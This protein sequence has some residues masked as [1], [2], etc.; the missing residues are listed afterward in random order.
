LAG[1]GIKTAK[2]F[3]AVTENAS[4]LAVDTHVHRVLN[5]IGIVHTK[6][7]EQTDKAAEKVF[8]SDDLAFLHH[9][10]IFF[11]RYHCTARKPKCETCPLQN[12]CKYY[13]KNF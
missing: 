4:F 1:V 2:V 12:I 3:L 13:K 5:R 10:L 8:T 9:T 11:G 7:P 6:T